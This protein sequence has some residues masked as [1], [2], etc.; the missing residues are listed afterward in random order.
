MPVITRE[1]EI[2]V[3]AADAFAYLSDHANVP[4][5]MFGVTSFDPVRPVTR[6]VGDRFD[7]G[8]K[9]GPKT[10]TSTLDVV[11]WVENEVF[12]LQSVAG[13]E[14]S[15]RWRVTPIDDD[16]C[17]ADVEFGYEFPGGLTGRALAKIVEPFIG[18]GVAMTD[19]NIRQ[20]L[21]V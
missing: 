8:M 18:Q 14:T 12:A 1:V 19:R 4:H 7:A 15:S 9:L 6:D 17:R 20:R 10:L 16:R 21:E 2:A 13:F 3:S 5:W 11:E